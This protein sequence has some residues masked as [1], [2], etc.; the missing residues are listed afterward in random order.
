M[1]TTRKVKTMPLE[2]NCEL[3]GWLD[4]IEQRQLVPDLCRG[5]FA[6]ERKNV[7]RKLKASDGTGK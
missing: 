5:I 2:L 1:E 6:M 3:F 4:A 7:K